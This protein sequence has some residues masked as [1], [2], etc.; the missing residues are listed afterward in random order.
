MFTHMLPVEEKLHHS[1]GLVYEMLIFRVMETREVRLFIARDGL[2][3]GDVVTESDSASGES[4]V[5][6]LTEAIVNKAK[7]KI[8]VNEFGH[9]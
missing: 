9:Y 8:D 1:R 5:V 4:T 3:V 7:N 6:D 2:G